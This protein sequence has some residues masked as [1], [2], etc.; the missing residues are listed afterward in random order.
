M[1]FDLIFLLDSYS[2]RFLPGFKIRQLVCTNRY[3][4]KDLIWRAESL[5]RFLSTSY[6]CRWLQ[7]IL[8]SVCSLIR[9]VSSSTPGSGSLVHGFTHD[10]SVPCLFLFRRLLQRHCKSFNIN[11]QKPKGLFTWREGAPDNWATQI[12]G[13]K[14]I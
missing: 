9:I 12:E 13:L 3:V 6:C 11:G 7:F 2:R 1:L 8:I 10:K 5:F 14:H 4:Y